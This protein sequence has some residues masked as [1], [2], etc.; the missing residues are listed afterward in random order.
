[1]TLDFGAAGAL[2]GYTVNDTYVSKNITKQVF[3]AR[4]ADCVPTTG[5]RAGAT[6][7]QDLWWNPAESG[8][9]L[10]ITHQG[11]KVFA[12]LFTY[13]PGGQGMWLAL[14]SGERQADGSYSGEIYRTMGPAFNAQP[15]TGITFAQV[16]TMRLRFQN[17]EAG[18]LEYSV[19]GINV[20][21]EITRQV[22]SSPAPLCAS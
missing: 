22:F 2:L 17:G 9:G 13:A 5:S 10:N 12:T 21:K 6:N 16:G 4:P 14:P 8:W 19:D 11:S 15:W 3:G 7:Y 1:M 18:T 20:T